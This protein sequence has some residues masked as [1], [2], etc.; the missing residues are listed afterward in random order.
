MQNYGKGR[1]CKKCNRSLGI[2]NKGPYC[3]AHSGERIRKTFVPV[4]CCTSF[5]LISKVSGIPQP[6]D[7]RY[8]D[9]AF[10][11]EVDILDLTG[12]SEW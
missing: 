11:I 9:I 7:E 3:H 5:E 12:D 8:N 6:G 10:N 1:K 2:Y 4:T